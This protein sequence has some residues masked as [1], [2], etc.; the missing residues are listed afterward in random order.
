MRKSEQQG[1]QN[2][3]WV[4]FAPLIVF[5]GLLLFLLKGLS[6]DPSELESVLIDD[7]VPQFSAV[8]LFNDDIHY[9]EEV[10]QQG[11]L[12]M[13]VW[14]TWCPT[15]RAEHEY[16]NQLAA[17]GIPIV[18][19]NYRDDS[20]A[21]AIDWLN[22]LGDPYIANIYDPEGDIAFEFGVYGAP[23]TYFIDAEGKIRYRHVGDVNERNWQNQLQ[24]IYQ[25][26]QQEAGS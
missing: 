24:Q 21:K 23:E 19:L 25:Q 9:S 17:E 4:L 7:P 11:P 10:L 16:L 13:N 15:C 6:S 8:D 14:A 1:A 18:G 26:M 20:R 12:L 22:T 5:I 3:W 2:R